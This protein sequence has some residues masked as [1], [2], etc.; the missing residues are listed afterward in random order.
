MPTRSHYFIH[1]GYRIPDIQTAIIR[2]IRGQ[3]ARPACTDSVTF[4]KIKLW[5]SEVALHGGQ[6]SGMVEEQ[7]GISRP[8]RD[9]V[10]QTLD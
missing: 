7:C 1:R 5:P 6:E 3:E 10:K 9:A 4:S 2:A 8:F